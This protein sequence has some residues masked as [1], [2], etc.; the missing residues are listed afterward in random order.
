MKR[1]VKEGM[2]YMEFIRSSE[3][4]GNGNRYE[5]GNDPNSMKEMTIKQLL[6]HINSVSGAA[7]NAISNDK[8]FENVYIQRRLIHAKKDLVEA[9]LRLMDSKHSKD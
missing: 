5:F 8:D 6:E 7:L 4:G 3:L 1:Q 9:Y 2:G